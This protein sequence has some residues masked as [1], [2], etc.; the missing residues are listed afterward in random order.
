MYTDPNHLRVQ[1]PGKVEMCIRDRGYASW[2]HIGYMLDA[3]KKLYPKK[4]ILV[5]FTICLLY[6]SVSAVWKVLL[7]PLPSRQTGL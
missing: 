3:I 6:T 2:E 7:L 1:D 5:D 4:N